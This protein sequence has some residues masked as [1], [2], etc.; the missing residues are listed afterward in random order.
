MSRFGLL[1]WFRHA[2]VLYHCFVRLRFML[3]VGL[4]MGAS[5]RHVRLACI[6]IVALH[7]SW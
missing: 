2:Y 1:A 4:G 6:L 3:A 5:F 7:L